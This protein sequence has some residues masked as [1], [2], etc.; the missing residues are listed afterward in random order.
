[1]LCFQLQNASQMVHDLL[2]ISQSSTSLAK[3]LH[4][5]QGA[6]DGKVEVCLACFLLPSALSEQQLQPPICVLQAP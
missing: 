5:G 4:G 6:G 3:W 1:M 2:K